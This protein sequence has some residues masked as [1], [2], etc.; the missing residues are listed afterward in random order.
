MLGLAY[1]KKAVRRTKRDSWHSFVENMNSQ[2][3]TTRLVKIIRRN[4]TMGVCNVIKHIGEFT[5]SPLE[6]LNYLLDIL[7]PGSQQTEKIMQPGAI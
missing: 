7:S 6:T 5:K 2:T 1:F 4:E 3:P